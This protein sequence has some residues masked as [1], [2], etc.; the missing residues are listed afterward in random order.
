M[1]NGSSTEGPELSK[2]LR[3]LLETHS[4]IWGFNTHLSS[5][6]LFMTAFCH[7]LKI[8]E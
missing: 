1:G 5:F 4:P 7:A 6:F 3:L 2:V 8:S